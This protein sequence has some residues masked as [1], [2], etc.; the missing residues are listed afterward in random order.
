MIV[1]FKQAKRLKELGYNIPCWNISWTTDISAPSVSDA[2]QWLR[3]E[4]EIPCAVEMCVNYWARS[5]ADA[6]YKGV[7][8]IGDEKNYSNRVC[9][10]P[11]AESDLL[12]AL[13]TY[14]EERK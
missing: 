4:K 7:F 5:Y 6:S 14:L 13:L 10:F 1:T 9:D 12:D 2:L 11:E 3:D 8:L